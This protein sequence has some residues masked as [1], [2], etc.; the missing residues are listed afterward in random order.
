MASRVRTTCCG[1]LTT[2]LGGSIILSDVSIH[3]IIKIHASTTTAKD[4]K[5]GFSSSK[6]RKGNVTQQSTAP[7]MK[8]AYDQ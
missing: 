7:N 4:M 1:P 2:C 5:F 3:L 6:H 8:M